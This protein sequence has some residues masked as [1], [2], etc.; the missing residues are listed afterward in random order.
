MRE[1]LDARA[2]IAPTGALASGTE[3]CMPDLTRSPTVWR[4]ICVGGA[5]VRVRVAFCNLRPKHTKRDQED[6]KNFV[7]LIGVGE[8]G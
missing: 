1:M 2:P 8:D 5:C 3:G 6:E 4:Q 7:T